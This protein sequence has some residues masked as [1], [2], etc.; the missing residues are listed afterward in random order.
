MYITDSSTIGFNLPD[1][2]EKAME[3]EKEH[4]DWARSETTTSI[5]YSKTSYYTVNLKKEV[6]NES[7]PSAD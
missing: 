5:A 3:F 7:I 6:Q 2:Y 4:P 1:E